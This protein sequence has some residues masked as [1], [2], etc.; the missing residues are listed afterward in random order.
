MVHEPLAEKL[1]LVRI[2]R[3]R[4][5]CDSS[6]RSAKI[7]KSSIEQHDND[8]HHNLT[9]ALLSIGSY[10][11]RCFANERIVAL[12]EGVRLNKVIFK[13]YIET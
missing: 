1:F 3:G 2:D 13:T 12:I 6:I 4:M 8:D 5:Q 11:V 9:S 10:A 7:I